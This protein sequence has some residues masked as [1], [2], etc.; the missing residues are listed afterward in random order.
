[1]VITHD[2]PIYHES[3]VSVLGMNYK[4]DHYTHQNF[5]QEPMFGHLCSE[6]RV[7]V[8]GKPEKKKKFGL[9]HGE[10]YKSHKALNSS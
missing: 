10:D 9:G 5:K 6:K 1:M 8:L 2:F 4:G 3:L 7:H